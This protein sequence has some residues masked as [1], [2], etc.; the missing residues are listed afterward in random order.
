MTIPLPS[1]KSIYSQEMLDKLAGAEYQAAAVYGVER[2]FL[3]FATPAYTTDIEEQYALHN[4]CTLTINA[5]KIHHSEQFKNALALVNSGHLWSNPAGI[6]IVNSPRFLFAA[7]PEGKFDTSDCDAEAFIA[8]LLCSLAYR[9]VVTRKAPSVTVNFLETM[10]LAHENQYMINPRHLL[11]YGPVSDHCSPYDYQKMIQFMY[12]FRNHTRILITAT[13][14]LGKLLAN[15][16]LHPDRVTY[17]F[18]FDADCN[19]IPPSPPS[20][21]EEKKKTK[22]GGRPKKDKQPKTNITV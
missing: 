1:I 22:T 8:H 6:I 10:Q 2:H 21:E 19:Y 9:V 20:V 3:K 4:Y 13:P 5:K 17:Y 7:A 14:D 16:K 18:N 11:V 15:I 12:S